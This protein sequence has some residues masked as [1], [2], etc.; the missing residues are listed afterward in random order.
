MTATE[1]HAPA[2]EAAAPPAKRSTLRY[3][4]VAVG[5]LIVVGL[6]GAAAW[7]LFPRHEEE[8]TAEAGEKGEGEHAAAD[9]LAPE[10]SHEGRKE[11]DL[12]EFSVTSF[13]PVSGTTL[14][15]NFHLYGAVL[16]ADDGEFHELFEENRHRF[17]ESVIVI[18]R[19]SDLADLTD[20]GLG[21]IKRKVL[22]KT[23]RALG[24]PLLKDVVFSEFSLV[25]H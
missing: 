23:N 9:P 22:E 5:I 20:A 18:V 4:L 7:M 24:K 10:G 1:A 21:L 17:R 25:E 19:S 16:E 12:G 14:S 11:V 3:I 8:P 13:Q 15:I 2:P 6:E